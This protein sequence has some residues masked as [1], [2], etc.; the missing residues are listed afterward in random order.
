M[1]VLRLGELADAVHER[2]RLDEVVELERALERVVDLAPDIRSATSASIYDRRT[3]GRLDRR[4]P[5]PSHVARRAR[6]RAGREL[7]LERSSARSPASSCPCSSARASRRPRSCSRTRRPGSSAAL[8][9]ARGELVVAALLLQVKTLLDNADGLLARASG[10]V[11]LA[12]RYLDT[13]A[14]LVVNAA[15]FAA[16]G[17]VDRRAVARA[18]RLP[19]ARRSSSRVDFNLA[20]L[21]R[22][23]TRRGDGSLP[24][25]GGSRVER[26]SG[27]LPRRVRAAGPLAAGRLGAEARAALAGDADR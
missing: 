9:L 13:E 15:L 21:Y 1:V 5:P 16:L 20:E 12:G 2:E 18:R 23:R 4:M 27:G 19:R 17:Y 24:R 10:R 25:S 7:V 11:T 26:V 3:D 8:A 14:D 6:R 22:E